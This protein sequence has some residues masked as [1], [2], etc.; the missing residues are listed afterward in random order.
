VSKHLAESLRD[1]G[2]M[3]LD[4]KVVYGEMVAMA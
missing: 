2:R 1:I 3:D 4:A